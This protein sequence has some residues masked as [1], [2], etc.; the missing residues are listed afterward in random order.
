MDMA[1]SIPAKPAASP[2][3]NEPR[4]KLSRMAALLA[5]FAITALVV[6]G[7]VTG[8]VSRQRERAALVNET[9]ELAVPTVTV[10]SPAPG[11]AA[12]TLLLPAEVKPWIDAPIYARASGYVKRWLVDIGAPVKAGELL[13]EIETPELDQQVDQARH[14]LAQAEAALALAKST[15]ERYTLLLKT[16]SVSE[17]D[18]DEKQS[19]FALK[20][21]SA[22][23]DRANLRRLENLQAF[24]R[25]TAPFAG[26][27]T[28]RNIDVGELVAA[29]NAKELFRLSQTDKLRVYVSVPQTDAFS[30]RADQPAEMLIPEFPGRVFAAKVVS[31]ASAIS[32]DSRTLLT[33]LEVDN[34]RND[35]LPGCFAQVR[36]TAAQREA[37]LVLPANTLLF[38]AEGPQVGV[39]KS[40]GTVELRTVKLG[41][42]FG[43]TI[44]IL[45]GVSATDKV[46][47]NPSDSLLNGMS[48]RVAGSAKPEKGR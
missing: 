42:D 31:T 23:A 6:A 27:I 38:R 1:D 16:A 19:D 20:T 17:Q 39:V 12:A 43:Q 37:S 48:M 3:A 35:L 7:V 26:T 10:V 34:S 15:A 44:E 33:Q 13:A 28:A 2:A 14:E 24:A 4:G 11:K 8:L 29:G 18:A 32:A 46:I 41:R 36:F 40:D 30:V 5:L 21:A 9:A 45:A 47:L 25:V 22:A